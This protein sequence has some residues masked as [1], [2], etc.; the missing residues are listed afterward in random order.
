M[1]K[2]FRPLS[3]H[4]I[5]GRQVFGRNGVHQHQASSER[6]GGLQGSPNG[7]PS[8]C[9][10]SRVIYRRC[11]GCGSEP[12]PVSGGVGIGRS[13]GPNDPGL[14]RPFTGTPIAT[15]IM[16]K[17]AHER[18][19]VDPAARSKTAAMP[20]SRG[21][22]GRISKFCCWGRCGLL[23]GPP[24]GTYTTNARNIG[25]A[26]SSCFPPPRAPSYRSQRTHLRTC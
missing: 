4:L 24:S 8:P 5:Q 19:S 20:R 12:R 15:K 6:R 16:P 10:A 23:R 17:H 18:R 2:C 9:C 3:T 1:K 14:S 21:R 7:I 11:S 26:D 13:H 25:G 22:N